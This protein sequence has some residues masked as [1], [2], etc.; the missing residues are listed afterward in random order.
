[1]K[2]KLLFLLA[3]G[4]LVSAVLTG[5]SLLPYSSNYTCPESKSGMGNCSSL[6]ANY[7]ISTGR[8]KT[9]SANQAGLSNCPVSLRGTK[10]CGE[11]YGTVAAKITAKEK[12]WRG[13]YISVRRYLLKKYEVEGNNPPLYAPSIIK[14]VWVLPYSMPA[15]FHGGEDVYIIVQKGHWLY[16]NYIFK[17]DE[18]NYNMFLIRR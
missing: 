14:K 15:V 9:P 4:F 10:A 8:I 17:K 5:C 1:M 13:G 16:G 12:N 6:E 2:K 11:I 7:K 3:S 18:K